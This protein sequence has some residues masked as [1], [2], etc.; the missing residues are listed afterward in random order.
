MTFTQQVL[1]LQGLKASFLK[2]SEILDRCALLVYSKVAVRLDLFYYC[3]NA[4]LSLQ[5][6]K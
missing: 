2:V 5:N 6:N 4:T 3:D 1:G